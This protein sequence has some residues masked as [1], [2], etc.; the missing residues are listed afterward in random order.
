MPKFKDTIRRENYNNMKI[1]KNK[2]SINLIKVCRKIW[3]KELWTMKNSYYS[4]LYKIK[5]N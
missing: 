2:Y 5:E 4:Q 3:K 1:R